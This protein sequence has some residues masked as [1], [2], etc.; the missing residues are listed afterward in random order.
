MSQARAEET[1]SSLLL[2]A[3]RLFDRHGYEGTSLA[4]ISDAAAVSKGAISFHFGNKAELA[5]AVQLLSCERSRTQLEAVRD[6]EG[7]ALQTLVDMTQ[8]AAHQTATD[9]LVRAGLRLAR[10]REVAPLPAINC[11]VA[12][13]T[14]L[15][16]TALRAREDS[17]LR[18]GICPGTVMELALSLALHQETASL[19]GSHTSWL[20]SAWEVVLPGLA[21][22]EHRWTF[23]PEGVH[24]PWLSARD[25]VP[26]SAATS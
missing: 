14:L 16:Q 9:A 19:D 13:R 23:R 22:T 18:V 15:W 21:P 1:R 10:E 17:S 6:P 8:T 11:R 12:W 26:R 2:A 25:S 5:D 20:T 3:A 7:P 24:V 4:T